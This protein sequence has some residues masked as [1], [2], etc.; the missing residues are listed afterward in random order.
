MK[1]TFAKEI[2]SF[3]VRGDYG[4][5]DSEDEDSENRKVLSPMEKFQ[6]SLK[7]H[8]NA[9]I[10]L[11]DQFNWAGAYE[12][13]FLEFF[14]GQIALCNQTHQ[15]VHFVKDFLLTDLKD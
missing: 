2:S 12:R 8:L 14:R 15:L 7:R 9:M 1:K 4:F 10:D 5:T 6:N 13:N 3:F 11:S